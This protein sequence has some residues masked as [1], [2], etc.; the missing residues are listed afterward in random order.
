[1][2]HELAPDTLPAGFFA[3]PARNVA[4]EL[5]G[6]VLVSTVDG[7]LTAGRITETEAYIGPQDPASHAAKRIG[8]TSRN[9][10]MFGPPG[11][12]YVYRI[13]G[14]HWCLNVVTDREAFPAAVLIRSL[15][16]LAGFDTMRVRRG[17][18]APAP[19]PVGAAEDDLQTAR[20]PED[21]TLTTGPGRLA[22]ALGVSDALDRHDL[23]APP[24]R[25]LA[26]RSAPDHDVASGPR[27]GVTRA[28]SWPLRF[29]LQ[30]S[31]WLSR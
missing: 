31:P 7:A 4:R 15:E 28:T 24:L 22:Q 3:R 30:R 29:F 5:L 1:M 9:Q 25:L 17:T 27:I 10:A 12:A 2:I 26:G 8:R 23:Q 6:A 19:V 18:A 21:R 11:T 16:P 20:N 13:Y 14:I